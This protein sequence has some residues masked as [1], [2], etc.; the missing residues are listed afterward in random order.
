MTK[1]YNFKVHN[2]IESIN[3]SEW[4]LCNSEGNLFT[5]YSFLKLLEDSK[6]LESRTGWHPNYFSLHSDNK[7][8]ACIAAY[9]KY[10]SQGEFV[11]DH[12][13]ANVYQKL[14]LNYY[15]KL[16]V[17]SPFTP[18]SG[19]RLLVKDKKNEAAKNVLIKN[20]KNFCINENLSSIHVN[21]INKN[22][23]N[24]FLKNNFFIKY[25][26]QFHFT[27][28]NYSTFQDFLASLSYK[29]RKAIIKERNMIKKMGIEIKV[30]KGNDINSTVLENLYKLYISTIEKK[31]SYD[32]LTKDFFLNLKNYL[33]EDL[34]IIAAYYEKRI[35]ALA[36]NF[37]SNNNLYGRYWGTYKNL[38]FLHFE[39]CYYKAIETAILF[40]LDKVEAG[41]QG[42]HKIKRGY[43]P[44]ATYSAHF[45]L[46]KELHHIFKK[47][48]EIEKDNIINEIKI[49]KKE[50]SPYKTNF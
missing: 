32:Y 38:P 10:N 43:V 19:A 44:T 50:Y 2:N 34:V 13:W 16:V 46:N 21:F 15:P 33:N 24:F 8:E 22:E 42:P 3:K 45:I 11:F 6:S 23:V 48:N 5:S 49:L 47:Y 12:S 31:W 39:L 25:G 17:A 27:N 37:I 26:E 35:L 41:A 36:L 40:K 18:I 9:K 4:N 29:K 30:L 20:L 7:I 28:N 1:K 14:G